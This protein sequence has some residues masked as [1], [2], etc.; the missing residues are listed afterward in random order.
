M[1]KVSRPRTSATIEASTSSEP[2]PISVAPQ[3]SVTPPPR[4]NFNCTPECGILFQYIGKP[5]PVRYAE[6]ASPTPRPSGSFRNLSRQPEELATRRMHSERFTVLSLKKLAVTALEDSAIRRR[7]SAGSICSFSAILSSC[8]SWPKRG[9]TVPCPRLGPQGG[10][11][12]K[13][14]QPWNL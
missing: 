13:V 12:V 6:Q 1:S 10:L 9:C 8:T 11:F 14:R 2:C 4:S 7:K 5:A 3:N